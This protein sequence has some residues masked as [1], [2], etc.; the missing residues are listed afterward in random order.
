MD[1][2]PQL[3]VCPFSSEAYSTAAPGA[4]AGGAHGFDEIVERQLASLISPLVTYSRL[5][6]HFCAA[7]CFAL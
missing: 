4:W 7:E 2:F 6:S 1:G 3:F 5:S